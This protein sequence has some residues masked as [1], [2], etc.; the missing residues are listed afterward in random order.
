MGQPQPAYRASR[1]HFTSNRQFL[2]LIYKSNDSVLSNENAWTHRTI[3]H[4]VM[5]KHNCFIKFT[6]I[7]TG[8]FQKFKRLLMWTCVLGC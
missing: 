4:Y 1:G 7:F 2:F 8:T 3:R 6:G 5:R